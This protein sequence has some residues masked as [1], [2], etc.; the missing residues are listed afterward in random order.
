M[1]TVETTRSITAHRG[2]INIPIWTLSPR[3]SIQVNLNSKE[4][5]FF[6]TVPKTI[7]EIRKDKHIAPMETKELSLG[8]L[9]VKKTIS[10]KEINGNS[11]IIQLCGN[12]LG[13][14]FKVTL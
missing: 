2:S 12:I 13:T 14:S 8:L 3:R 6:K 10:T 4:I 7:K 5:G 9:L 11:G 1:E